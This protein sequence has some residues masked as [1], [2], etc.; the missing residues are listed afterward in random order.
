MKNL[1]LGFGFNFFLCGCSNTHKVQNPTVCINMSTSVSY[2]ELS[3]GQLSPQNPQKNDC[4]K[5]AAY[6]IKNE[7]VTLFQ[8]NPACHGIVVSVY[9]GTGDTSVLRSSAWFLDFTAAVTEHKTYLPLT[10]N[11]Q[12]G[13]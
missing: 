11:V 2:S 6:H 13:K 12:A 1:L 5:T 3:C 8:T 9:D 4:A 7:F 10:G